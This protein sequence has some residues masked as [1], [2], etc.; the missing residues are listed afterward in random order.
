MTLVFCALNHDFVILVSDRRVT[1]TDRPPIEDRNKGVVYAAIGA[2]AYSG[3]AEI[4]G[5]STDRWLANALKGL[6]MGMDAIFR[7]QKSAT[8]AFDRMVLDPRSKRHAF[9][10]AGWG[11]YAGATGLVPGQ[12]IVSNALDANGG[13]L[14]EARS[15]FTCTGTRLSESSVGLVCNPVGAPVPEDMMVELRADVEHCSARHTS[16]YPIMRRLAETIWAVSKSDC[17]VGKSLLAMVFPKTATSLTYPAKLKVGVAYT[18][19]A[20]KSSLD[21]PWVCLIPGDGAQ[22]VTVA[23]FIVYGDRVFENLPLLPANGIIESK[24]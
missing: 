8:S 5:Q 23:P 7:L 17:T 10:G 24:A 12:I 13:W 2:V 16:P 20:R 6:P 1:Y 22:D 3:L 14:A 21:V 18:A 15:E 19:D 11:K 4:D 9:V